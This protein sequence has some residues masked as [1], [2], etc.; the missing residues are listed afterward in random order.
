MIRYRLYCIA[1]LSIAACQHPGEMIGPVTEKHGSFDAYWN[2]GLA[3]L[4]SYDLNQARYGEMHQ[5]EAI[6]IFVTEDLSKEKQVK[7][8]NTSV[9]TDLKVA[10]LKMNMTKRFY[11]GLYPYTMMLSSFVPVTGVAPWQALKATASIQDWCGHVFAQLNLR[12]DHYHY[13]L[14]SYFESEGEIDHQINRHMTEDAVW[15]LIRI[16]PEAL[17]ASDSIMV[18]PGLFYARLMHI[19]L[20]PYLAKTRHLLLDSGNRVYHI[21]YPDLARSLY[22]EYETQS[23]YQIVKWS[24]EYK[25]GFGDKA[26]MLTTTA[27]KKKQLVLDY[28]TKHDNIHDSLRSELGLTPF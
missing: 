18:I 1:L 22:I 2:Q 12:H 7:L 16:N 27:S 23:P 24:E 3:E 9:A 6:L 20:K 13:Q 21:E 15:N 26:T 17:I 14:H 10:V 5:G 25:D 4:T 11:T 8:D 28:W 19:P